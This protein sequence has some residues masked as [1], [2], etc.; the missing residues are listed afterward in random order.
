MQTGDLDA[1][2]VNSA[3]LRMH[4]MGQGAAGQ[5]AAWSMPC[6][7]Q[8]RCSCRPD[9]A[10]HF[11]AVPLTA[12]VEGVDGLEALAGQNQIC[13]THADDHSELQEQNKVVGPAVPLACRGGGNRRVCWR[14]NA[15]EL[16]AA[17]SSF[18]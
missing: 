13:D 11:S 10:S 17:S 8:R 5:G 16:P 15:R 6:C 9:N 2:A 1:V 7:F 12:T 3:L 18:T 4:A 14:Q